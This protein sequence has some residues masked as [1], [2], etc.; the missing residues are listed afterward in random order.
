VVGGVEG[1]QPLDLLL[2]FVG[3]RIISLAHMR[4]QRIAPAWRQR[5][6]D[7]DRSHRRDLVVGMIRVPSAAD[8][9]DLIRPFPHYCDFRMVVRQREVVV[10]VDAAPPPGKGDM[11]VGRE[12]V[13]P[14]KQ[15]DTVREDRL[16]YAIQFPAIHTGQ[17]HTG[18]FD[19]AL[20]RQRYGLHRFSPVRLVSLCHVIYAL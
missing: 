19:P 7:Q 17:I 3:Q 9:G 5:P 13:L 8:I 20:R 6:R 18:N 12:I 10:D 1:L 16:L 14:A 4:P 15:G 11:R 2:Q